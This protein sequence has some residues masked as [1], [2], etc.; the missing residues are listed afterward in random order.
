MT[1]VTDTAACIAAAAGGAL[2]RGR[3]VAEESASRRLIAYWLAGEPRKL[4]AMERTDFLENSTLPPVLGVF[5]SR[6]LATQVKAVAAV[7]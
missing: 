2:G 3:R 1:T 4:K 7:A 6:V 5:I